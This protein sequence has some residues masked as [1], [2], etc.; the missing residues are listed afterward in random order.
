MPETQLMKNCPFCGGGP[1]MAIQHAP[2]GSVSS[3][4]AFGKCKV[5]GS[6]GKRFLI[7]QDKELGADVALR[8]ALDAWNLR[9]GDR[10]NQK[11]QDS[12]LND[13]E[14]ATVLQRRGVAHV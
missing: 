14:E 6:A 3:T 8:Q 10:N 12:G 2:P 11:T 1:L 13:L 9:T 5:C 7:R 4:V